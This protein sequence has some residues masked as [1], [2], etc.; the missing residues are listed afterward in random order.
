MFCEI[1]DKVSEGLHHK[2]QTNDWMMQQPAR[3]SQTCRGLAGNMVN[4][5]IMRQ[6]T[7]S[8]GHRNLTSLKRKSFAKVRPSGCPIIAAQVQNTEEHK[9][10]RK[11]FCSL[12]P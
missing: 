11:D 3:Q 12:S 4:L 5:S 6:S 1:L 10:H 2:R 9:R 7:S 8:N